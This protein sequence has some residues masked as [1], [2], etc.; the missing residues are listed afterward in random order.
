MA[1]DAHRS[2]IPNLILMVGL[3]LMQVILQ[4]V[5]QMSADLHTDHQ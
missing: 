1:I 3:Q 2:S 4:N 5:L